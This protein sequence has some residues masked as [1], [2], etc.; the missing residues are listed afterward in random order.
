MHAACFCSRLSGARIY[1]L[2]FCCCPDCLARIAPQ[3]VG[4]AVV[5]YS[6]DVFACILWCCLAERIRRVLDRSAHV[7]RAWVPASVHV[8]REVP[9]TSVRSSP[10]SGAA[11]FLSPQNSVRS[12][13][14]S[15][16]AIQLRPRRPPQS[17]FR[18]VRSHGCGGL[19]GGLTL[20]RRSGS[21]YAARR[22]AL[23]SG[24][25]RMSF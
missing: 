18:R 10:E 23:S 16:V 14:P 12:S 24:P 21:G 8:S 19:S 2:L 7:R 6:F 9:A 25:R 17:R 1:F 20:L 22:G 15:V 3:S 5:R 11:W 13:R 4:L